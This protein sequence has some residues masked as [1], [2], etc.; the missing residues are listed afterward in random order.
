M[1]ANRP[2]FCRAIRPRTISMKKRH[3]VDDPP[4]GGFL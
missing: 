4:H 2:M 1:R 3:P